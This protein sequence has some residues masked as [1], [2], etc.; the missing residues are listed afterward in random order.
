MTVLGIAIMALWTVLCLVWAVLSIPGGL[1]ANASG[2]FSPKAHMWM[3]ALLAIGQLIV[4]AAGIPGGRA[5]FEGAERAPLLWDMA[6]LAG[7]GAA[8]QIG[9]VTAFFTFGRR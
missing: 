8:L 3:L 5:F 2:G 1:M 9:A 6:K 7:L 4:L